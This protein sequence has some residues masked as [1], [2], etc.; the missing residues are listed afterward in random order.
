LAIAGLGFAGALVA[1]CEAA[2]FTLAAAAGTVPGFF[3]VFPCVRGACAAPAFAFAFA[4]A[5]T[6]ARVFRVLA[7]PCPVVAAFLPGDGFP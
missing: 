2:G 6:E 4:L 3:L 1:A 5:L 7:L